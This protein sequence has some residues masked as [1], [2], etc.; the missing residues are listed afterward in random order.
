MRMANGETG[1]KGPAA[2]TEA[3]VDDPRHKV[4]QDLAADSGRNLIP[5]VAR[6]N[7]S[8]KLKTAIED[9]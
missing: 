1:F 6:C 7:S 2:K 3:V 5:Q 4:R 9:T 8:L